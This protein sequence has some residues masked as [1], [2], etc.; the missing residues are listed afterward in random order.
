MHAVIKV[1]PYSIE[2]VRLFGTHE[3]A[4]KFVLTSLTKGHLVKSLNQTIVTGVDK[5]EHPL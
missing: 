3:L 5:L 4:R 2:N 1:A